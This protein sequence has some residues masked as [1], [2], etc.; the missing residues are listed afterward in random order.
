MNDIYTLPTEKRP[1]IQDDIN[2]RIGWTET[3][4]RDTRVWLQEQAELW[5][6]KVR[7]GLDITG[8]SVF[9]IYSTILGDRYAPQG[10]NNQPKNANLIEMLNM[11][12]E[13][14]DHSYDS[15]NVRRVKEFQAAGIEIFSIEFSDGVI[16]NF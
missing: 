16:I 15:I 10:E 7:P 4:N 9:H 3:K 6:K 14:Q 12:I 8:W 2:N 13:V 11:L 1:T 5:A